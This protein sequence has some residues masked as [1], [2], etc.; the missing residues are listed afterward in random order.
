MLIGLGNKH[1]IIL[2]VTITRK[3]FLITRILQSTMFIFR[4]QNSAKFCRIWKQENHK[5]CTKK[6]MSRWKRLSLLIIAQKTK[7]QL[8]DCF[9]DFVASFDG[10][11][12][13]FKDWNKSEPEKAVFSCKYCDK[14]FPPDGANLIEFYIFK[15]CHSIGMDI[16]IFDCCKQS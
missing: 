4:A 13:I 10:G 5:N 16:F 14:K 12:S 8:G 15:C 9:L 11:K 1:S 7:M 3:G 2:L 6:V